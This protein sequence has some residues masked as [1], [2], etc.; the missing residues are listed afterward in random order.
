MTGRTRR[1]IVVDSNIAATVPF[2]MEKE[3]EFQVAITGKIMS[4]A[5]LDGER[6]LI[7]TARNEVNTFTTLK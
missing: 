6:I 3:R 2:I 7:G 1:S 4:S 5:W